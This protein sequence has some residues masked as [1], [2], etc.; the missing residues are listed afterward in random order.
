[1]KGRFLSWAFRGLV[2]FAG[3]VLEAVDTDPAGAYITDILI[4]SCE[5]DAAWVTTNGAGAYYREHLD[6]EWVRVSDES[7]SD[8]LY[9]V[10]E[11]GPERR[12]VFGGERTGPPLG[13]NKARLTVL[14]IVSDMRDLDCTY[15][16]TPEGVWLARG[17]L[18]YSDSSEWTLVFDYANWQ[19]EN[20]K[21]DWPEESWRFTRFQKL[22]IDPHNPDRLLLGARWEGGYHE[23]IDGGKS[24][25]HRGIGGLF[26]RADVLQVDPH[27]PQVFYAFTHHQGMFQSFNQGQS[28]VV[29]G[30]GLLPQ[31]RSPVYGA[32]LLG[33]ISFDPSKPGRMLAGSDYSTWLT[34]DYGRTWQEVG[35]TLTCEF[36]RATAFHPTRPSVLYAGSNVGFYQSVDGGQTWEARNAGF[37][38]KTVLER[39]E[40]EIEGRPFE[41]VRV[42]GNHPVY[43][44]PLDKASAPWR[45]M[46]WML[47]RPAEDLEWE[48]ES[49]RLILQT[50][51]GILTSTD[52]GFRWSIPE[53]TFDKRSPKF[54]IGVIPDVANSGDLVIQNA[55]EPRHDGLLDWYKRPPHVQVQ[56]VEAGYPEN[57]SV[58]LWQFHWDFALLGPLEIPSALSSDDLFLYVEVRDF[59][60]GTR[61]G[62]APYNPEQDIHS[63]SVHPLSSVE[64]W[65]R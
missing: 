11:V 1:M 31:K 17:A 41:Y 35:K 55:V 43:R 45:S 19:K 34:Q 9:V 30:A 18:R 48:G 44:R 56:L 46:N 50:Q 13:A 40:C 38:K 54:A 33:G 29:R 64:L 65:D 12:V 5:P 32:Y 51:T 39:I 58:P 47:S 59:Q 63:I 23:S 15:V 37:P 57:G 27:N 62:W 24:W 8:K 21:V 22:T 20:R 14:D 6:A 4:R 28:W 26:R 25:Q 36:V 16:L 3:V 61:V 7:Q 49:G 60:E 2:L 42:A 10:A 52:G 53:I